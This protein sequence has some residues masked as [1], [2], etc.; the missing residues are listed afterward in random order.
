MDEGDDEHPK[1]V[2]S[3]PSVED[4][5]L[6]PSSSGSCDHTNPVCTCA[7][8]DADRAAL[9]EKYLDVL[10]EDGWPNVLL[11]PLDKEGKG[12]VIAGR[13][14]LLKRP[15]RE[16]LTDEAK[17]Y[18]RT[19]SEAVDAVRAG[20]RG[21]CLYAGREDLGTAGLVFTDHDDPDRFPADEHTLTVV[22]GSGE[23]Y[24]QTFENG[25]DVR[26]AKGK[27][28]LNG[29]GEV[30]A[31]TQYVVL[32]G[33]IHPSGGIY[34]IES[35]PG[36]EQLEPRDLPTELRPGSEGREATDSDDIDLDTC[37][38]NALGKI[39]A[40]V[41]VEYRYQTMLNCAVAET[42]RAV[43][44]GTLAETR[45]ENDRH[46][47]EGWLAEQ[48][49]FYMGRDREV[50]HQVLMKIFT[51]NPQTD[52]H[53]NDPDKSSG[54]KYLENEH[55]RKQVLDYATSKDNEYDPGHGAGIHYTRTERPEVSYPT[56]E[57]VQDALAEL[58]LASTSEIT[59]HPR[60]DRSKQ[61]VRRALN[62]MLDSEDTPPVVKTV[63]DGRR[64]YYYLESHA[65]FIDEDRR[66]ELGIDLI[67]GEQ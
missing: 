23:G 36:I 9:L 40:E 25:G 56:F 13:C 24:H 38:P 59:D 52:A 33:S 54:R 47:A 2:S 44:G 10:A 61:Q 22:S 15:E 14:R 46:Q 4:D 19:P 42:I 32:P 21:F 20:H 37:V 12:P 60:V 1:E 17:S 57:R 48:V 58:L 11:M 41:N 64:R 55:H 18:L 3:M 65:I 5:R 16:A 51:E 49:G 50:V 53:R 28:E 29:A 7:T 31:D 66:E 8:S 62:E 30:R 67:T 35:N 34:H 63:R 27:K 45:F 6:N 26:N 43:I 39:E